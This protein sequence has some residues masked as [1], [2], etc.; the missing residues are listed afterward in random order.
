MI[1]VMRAVMYKSTAFKRN[2]LESVSFRL[3]FGSVLALQTA[4]VAA[5][6]CNDQ[7]VATTP[8]SAFE[9]HNDGTVTHTTTGLMWKVC[10]E[11]QT[12]AAGRCIGTVTTHTWDSALQISQTLNAGGG[13]PSTSN[14]TNWRLPNIKELKSIV[15]L[16]CY[17]PAMNE[18]VF[19]EAAASWFWS[20]SPFANNS[21]YAWGVGFN[22]GYDYYINRGYNYRVRLVRS[23][24]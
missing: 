24:Q 9:V 7:V 8:S 20:S 19:S 12:W 14:Y 10:A 23:G 3:L 6:T 2:R 16:K 4:W 11:G 5:Q 18:T 22:Y 13:Y 17:N 15:E 1:K 21:Y